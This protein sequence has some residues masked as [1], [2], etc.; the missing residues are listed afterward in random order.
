MKIIARPNSDDAGKRNLIKLAEDNGIFILPENALH[1]VLMIEATEHGGAGADSNGSG[2][3]VTNYFGE[4]LRPFC[5]LSHVD[6]PNGTHAYFLVADALVTVEGFPESNN[7]RITGHSIVKED[8]DP[9]CLRIMS[10]EMWVGAL[11]DLPDIAFGKFRKAAEAAHA[12]GHCY[13][14]RHVH[15]M[16][17]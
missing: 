7:I 9:R 1:A 2:T 11:A 5:R 16:A 8:N 3:I 6:I 10:T 13:H 15:F 17:A 4:P 14:C 12:K